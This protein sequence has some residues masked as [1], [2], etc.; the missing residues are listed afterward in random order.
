MA[1]FQKRFRNSRISEPSVTAFETDRKGNVVTNITC[2]RERVVLVAGSGIV[3]GTN[4]ILKLIMRVGEKNANSL[5]PYP[6]YGDPKWFLTRRQDGFQRLAAGN[7][8]ESGEPSI[9]FFV[10]KVHTDDL[11][12][13]KDLYFCVGGMS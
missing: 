13:R 8:S 6:V 7:Q 12:R 5:D 2:F 10:D 4:S 3:P 9:L 11:M 1:D